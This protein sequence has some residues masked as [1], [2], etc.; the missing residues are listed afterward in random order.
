MQLKKTYAKKNL[1]K[2]AEFCTTDEMI[3]PN[4]IVEG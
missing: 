1:P 3:F 4:A 2:N